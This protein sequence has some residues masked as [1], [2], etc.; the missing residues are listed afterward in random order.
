MSRAER[1]TLAGWVPV[2][3]WAGGALHGPPDPAHHTEPAS[4]P[5]PHSQSEEPAPQGYPA[6][7]PVAAHTPVQ[8]REGRA[9]QQQGWAVGSSRGGCPGAHLNSGRHSSGDSWLTTHPGGLPCRAERA[10]GM[11]RFTNS[12][13]L[14]GHQQV[15]TQGFASSNPTHQTTTS[16]VD[17]SPRIPLGLEAPALKGRPTA[18]PPPSPSN[19]CMGHSRPGSCLGQ[20]QLRTQHTTFP[21]VLPPKGVDEGG[22]AH[23]GNSDHHDTVVQI[24]QSPQNSVTVSSHTYRAT[25]PLPAPSHTH[26]AT[27]PWPHS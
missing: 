24:L 20:T 6:E 8:G 27:R 17:R 26:R 3:A 19:L 1:V 2:P 22:F 21:E 13:A 10:V 9:G 12:E 7:T 14:S 16:Q 15:Q 11:A 18:P 25:R 23:I 4:N 5:S